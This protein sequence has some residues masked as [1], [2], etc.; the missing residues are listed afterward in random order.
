LST[1]NREFEERTKILVNRKYERLKA[2]DFSFSPISILE[3]EKEIIEKTNHAAERKF[4]ENPDQKYSKEISLEKLR[5]LS[6]EE[7]EEDK[8]QTEFKIRKQF[9][10]K[11]VADPQ[12]TSKIY[13]VKLP[14]NNDQWADILNSEGEYL[15]S[16]CVEI[17]YIRDVLANALRDNKYI[18]VE[19]L[20]YI[21]SFMSEHEGYDLED[22]I[23]PVNILIDLNKQLKKYY[24]N[25]TN[26]RSSDINNPKD[27]MRELYSIANRISFN[28]L[29]GA[30]DQ[31]QK[32]IKS[33]AHLTNLAQLI[34]VIKTVYEKIKELDIGPLNGWAIMRD[35]E[36]VMTRDG[37]YAIFLT[38]ET[39]KEVYEYFLKEVKIDIELGETKANVPVDLSIKQVKISIEKGIEFC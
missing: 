1:L 9:G 22:K 38:E 3:I 6:I 11:T 25:P 8:A 37:R 27:V 36:I 28:D 17:S 29:I 30:S 14:L 20:N 33:V 12:Q 7:K 34:P 31:Q 15:P 24:R 5:I 39:V 19:D 21:A 10:F 16:C 23:N 13:R 2:E 26:T 18:N 32:D 4:G 35:K